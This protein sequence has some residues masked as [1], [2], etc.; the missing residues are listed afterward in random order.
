MRYTIW[1]PV[2]G[3]SAGCLAFLLGI[4]GYNGSLFL[5][6]TILLAAIGLVA[7]WFADSKNK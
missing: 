3:L 5:S 4:F 6:T 2:I 7:G 1:G